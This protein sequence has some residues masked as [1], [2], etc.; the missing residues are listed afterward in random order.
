MANVTQAELDALDNITLC[1]ICGN[2]YHYSITKNLTSGKT[3]TVVCK[4]CQKDIATNSKA[5]GWSGKNK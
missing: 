5:Q 4:N 3:Q 1:A 2:H